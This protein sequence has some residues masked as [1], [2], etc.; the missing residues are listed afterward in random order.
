[1]NNNNELNKYKFY[2][3]NYFSFLSIALH[4]FY[5]QCNIKQM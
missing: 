2:Y 3:K 5:P 1:M 4:L